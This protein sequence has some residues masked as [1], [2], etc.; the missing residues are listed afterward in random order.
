MKSRTMSQSLSPVPSRR[1]PTSIGESL[2]NTLEDW[3]KGVT[4]LM[5]QSFS[6][7]GRSSSR[8]GSMRSSVSSM[9]ASISQQFG[10]LDEDMMAVIDEDNFRLLQ[11]TLRSKGCVTNTYIQMNAGKYVQH[12]VHKKQQQDEEEERRSSVRRSVSP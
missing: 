9:D 4:S 12:V 3:S 11:K 2:S 5:D 7:Y 10:S 6:D 8:T 1:R